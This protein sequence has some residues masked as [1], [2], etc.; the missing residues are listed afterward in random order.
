MHDQVGGEQDQQTRSLQ[1]RNLGRRACL[2]RRPSHN[3]SRKMA[4][5][6]FATVLPPLSSPRASLSSA[7]HSIVDVILKDLKICTRRIQ[8]ALSSHRAELQVLEKLYYKGN[9]QHRTALFWRRVSDIRRCGRRVDE[10]QLQE[11]VERLRQSFWGEA[12]QQK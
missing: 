11:V 9:N 4:P 3:H 2:D 12:A 7:S 5:R 6:R 8:A 10:I 1:P